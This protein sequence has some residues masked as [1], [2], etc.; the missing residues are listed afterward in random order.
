MVVAT[1]LYVAHPDL[2]L[3]PT[4]RSLPDI[5]IG[6][7]SDAGTD[8]EHD[9]HFFWIEAP[10]YDDV[11]ERLA[12]DH[13][14]RAYSAIVDTERRRTYRIDFSTDA[15][16]ITPSIVD[17]GG[18]MVESRSYSDGW[19]LHLQLRDH[20]ALFVINEYAQQNDIHLDILELH[21]NEEPDDELEFGL[22][23]AQQE[24]LVSA[25]VQGYYDEP[26]KT[27]LEELGSNLGITSTSVSGRLRRG[28]AKLIE[29]LLVD[30]HE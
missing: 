30:D 22:T 24:A 16:L 28:S 13:T 23:K 4:I 6:V 27:S 15:M 11:E 12:A 17:A 19:M 7:Y 8:P 21:Q 1:K 10:D 18:L 26:R 20:G 3:S 2:P 29:E 9:V 25:Y 14:V 5:E